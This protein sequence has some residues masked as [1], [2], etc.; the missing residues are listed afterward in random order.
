[1]KLL[2][3]LLKIAAL[4]FALI[5]WSVTNLRNHLF[6]IGYTRTFRFG[7]RTIVVGN[8]SAGGSGKTPMVEYILALL[9][10]NDIKPAALS[11]GYKRHTKGYRLATAQDNALTVGDEP[12]QVYLKFGD[13]VAVAVGEE[14]AFAI[15]NILFERP[16]TKA[17]VLDDAFQ[18]RYV[19]PDL[20]ILLTD[21]SRPFFKDYILPL[22]RLREMRKG[23]ARAG[24]A[25]TTKC[26]QTITEETMNEYEGKI[27]RYAGK[28]IPVF[29]STIDY[30]EPKQVYDN[31]AQQFYGNILLVTGIAHNESLIKHIT[32]HFRLIETIA[33]PDHHQYTSRDLDLVADKF[34]K[35]PF[36][37]KTILTTEK[38]MVKMLNLQENSRL[39]FFSF[40]YL[41]IRVRFLKNG[42]IFDQLLLDSIKN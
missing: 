38:D 35:A 16:E 23:A 40:Y 26:P 14:R 3:I 37:K 36:E 11:R 4:P 7:V 41:P 24:I 5:Y 28:N 18:H 33:F 13:R 30:E 10:A 42:R 27:R 8:L 31:P 19:T 17:I 9:L 22:G 15:P 21:Y 6:D 20:N 29:F 2:K 12:Y 32:E 25:V 34:E 39:R 1:M